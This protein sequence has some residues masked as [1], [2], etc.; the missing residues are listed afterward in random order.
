MRADFTRDITGEVGTQMSGWGY[1][2]RAARRRTRMCQVRPVRARQPI[3][4]GLRQ[5]TDLQDGVL[6]REQVLGHGFSD[7][8][9]VRLVREQTWRRIARGVY[10]TR[11]ASPP[12]AAWAWSGVLLGGDQARLA[13]LAAAHLQGLTD[14]EP[15]EITVLVPYGHG[16]PTVPGPWRFRR[17]RLRARSGRTTGSPPRTTVEDTVLD[18]VAQA[19]QARAA[20]HWVTTAVQRR[21][22]TP[23]RLRRA[24]AD[25]HFLSRRSLLAVLLDDVAAGARSPLE[26]DFLR[27]VERA[28]G[29][30]AGVRQ[31]RQRGTEVDVYYQEFGVL[32]ELDGRA[33]H[34]GSGRFRDMSRDNA[35]LVD[36]LLT[37]RFGYGDVAD[38]PCL[39]ARQLAKVLTMRGWGGLLIPCPRCRRLPHTIAC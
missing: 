15:G 2:G 18:L 29:L 33:G 23:A 4:A 11:D 17:E 26:L 39:L 24:A 21:V 20:E 35:A 25:R 36:G 5:L 30:P 31:P 10:F 28:H 22:T 34:V 7:A 8:G 3:P 6:T 12:W 14:D 9:I 1:L 38:R 16:V 27:D 13:G 32:V 19:H 37:L